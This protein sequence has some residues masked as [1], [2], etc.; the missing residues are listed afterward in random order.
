MEVRYRAAGGGGVEGDVGEATWLGLAEKVMR[1]ELSE[2]SE[3]WPHE[4]GGSETSVLCCVGDLIDVADAADADPEDADEIAATMQEAFDLRCSDVASVAVDP[5][6]EPEPT[7]E[8]GHGG[9]N[10]A[11]ETRLGQLN[12]S[13]LAAFHEAR[14]QLDGVPPLEVLAYVKSRGFDVGK[15]VQQCRATQQWR[16]ERKPDTV[17]IADVAKFMRTPEGSAGPDGCMFVLE[18]GKGDCARDTWGRPIVVSTGMC[19]GTAEEQQ[20]QMIYASERVIALTLPDAPPGCSNV[21]EVVPQEGAEIT[22]RFPDAD[23]R[24]CFDLQKAHYPLSLSSTNHFVGIPRALTWGFKLCKPFMDAGEDTHTQPHTEW[25]TCILLTRRRWLCTCCAEAYSNMKL[26]PNASK[27][28][29][30]ISP[31]SRYSILLFD[32]NETQGIPRGVFPGRGWV[33]QNV[34]WLPYQDEMVLRTT[35]GTINT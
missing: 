8:L 17:T 13:Q 22:F 2:A 32:S 14:G 31:V 4:A 25:C 27:L 30:Y 3:V 7:F 10:S 18:D 11:L 19:H 6:P 15:A 26:W 33:Q 21:L 34:T 1:G 9:Q 24:S 29:D 12:A 20:I 5:E 23:V 16:A 35:E 28:P